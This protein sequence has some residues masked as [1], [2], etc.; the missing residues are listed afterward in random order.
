ME[1][2]KVGGAVGESVVVGVAV[3]ES[4]VGAE[5]G[6][7]AVVGKGVE[8]VEFEDDKEIQNNEDKITSHVQNFDEHNDKLC[9]HSQ[10]TK[11]LT[12]NYTCP[13]LLFQ[14]ERQRAFSKHKTK[15]QSSLNE[16][17]KNE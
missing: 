8:V 7:G 13:D 16:I 10:V 9:K 11:S 3:G 4:V 15:K 12:V 5:V 6:E 2:G 1:G 14:K 17:G